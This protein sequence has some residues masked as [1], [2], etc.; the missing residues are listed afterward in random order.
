MKI[1][2]LL[3]ATA[4]GLC[5]TSANSAVFFFG[6]SLTDTGN[7]YAASGN[8]PALWPSYFA[9]GLAT[10]PNG[11]G[12]WATR[13]AANLGGAALPSLTGGTN[14]AWSGARTY[15]AG[16][17]SS[18]RPGL[19]TQVGQYLA[20]TPSSNSSDVFAI[21]IGGN[22]VLPGLQSGNAAGAISNGITNIFN[23]VTALYNDGA[24][25]FLIANMPNVPA[26]P[27][28]QDLGA[29]AIAG[30]GQFAQGWNFAFSGLVQQISVLY[31][32]ID[33]DVLDLY[34]LGTMTTAEY[35]AEGITN[36][37]DRCI[38]AADPATACRSYLYSDGF[39][40]SSRAH[41]VIA[42]DA[43][44]AVPL[45]GSLA[46]LGLGLLGFFAARRKAA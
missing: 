44:A 2:K 6:D 12:V 39:H 22:D 42:A 41:E 9:P 33:L 14:Y 27:D 46:L 3:A 16:T 26:T 24:R 4:V 31:S 38:T 13:F 34:G 23:A 43:T 37:K 17:G 45:P 36:T 29:Q 21:V 8:N 19:G 7:L 5:A 10:D 20:A 32:G 1:K 40:P 30:T 25:R 15:D 28:V 11:Q 18:Y 35:A